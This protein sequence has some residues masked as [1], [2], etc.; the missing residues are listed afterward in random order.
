V[1]VIEQVGEGPQGTAVLSPDAAI[2][3]IHVGSK[4]TGNLPGELIHLRAFQ[5]PDS[6]L[7]PFAQRLQKLLRG[8]RRTLGDGEWRVSWADDGDICWVT[9]V[10]KTGAVKT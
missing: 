6:T 10:E 4:E 5:S 9:A 1:L 8:L 7:P 3:P 2:D